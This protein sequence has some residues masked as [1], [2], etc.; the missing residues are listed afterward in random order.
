LP[1]YKYKVVIK[2]I[3]DAYMHHTGKDV[4]SELGN[5]DFGKATLFVTAKDEEESLA[6][7]KGITDIN[8]WVADSS[9]D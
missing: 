4:Y 1:S 8:M 2:A 3:E 6:I 5:V 7:R 9:N